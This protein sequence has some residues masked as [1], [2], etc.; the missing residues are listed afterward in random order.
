MMLP[1]MAYVHAITLVVVGY[2]LAK[3]LSVG[4]TKLY[5]KQ[6]GKNKGLLL[7][8][9]IFYLILILF[10]ISAFHAM[11]FDLGILLGATGILTVAIGFAS[12]TSASNIIS[13]LFL[14]GERAFNVGDT[15]NINNIVGEVLSIDLLSV[16]IRQADNT[17]VRIPNATAINTQIINLSRFPTRRVDCVLSVSANAN[18]NKIRE[19]LLAALK[20]YPLGLKEPEPTLVVKDLTDT[21]VHLRLSVWSLQKNFYQA[22]NEIQELALQVLNSEKIAVNDGTMSVRLIKE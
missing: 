2:V 22:K 21:L 14:I 18:I 8:K 4:A 12:Q 3:L 13:G 19:T 5:Q 6:F 17:L 15:L 11:G 9:S 16:K 10:V 7:K 20:S 1:V